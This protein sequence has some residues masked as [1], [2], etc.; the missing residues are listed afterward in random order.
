MNPMVSSTTQVLLRGEQTE[1]L[2][3]LVEMTVPLGFTGPPL[4]IHSTWDEG[5]YVLEGEV[6]V[7][8]GEKLVSATRGMFAF[9]PRETAHTFAN[10]SAQDARILVL[11][12]PAGFERYLEGRKAGAPPNTRAVGP[13]ILSHHPTPPASGEE[14]DPKSR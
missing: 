7:Q 8:I 6:S 13:S 10:H 9:A 12:S 1:G 11:V 5:F 2:V 14:V 4:H 3:A